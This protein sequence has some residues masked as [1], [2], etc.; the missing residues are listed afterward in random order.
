MKDNIMYK[1]RLEKYLVVFN[2]LKL[3]YT[4]INSRYSI[5]N[6]KIVTAWNKA[7]D[8][9]KSDEL[10]MMA[11]DIVKG[12]EASCK[13]DWHKENKWVWITPELLLRADKREFWVNNYISNHHVNK[14]TPF[15]K[16]RY[17]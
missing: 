15:K 7:V 1:E 10:D 16:N 5:N 8:G 3:K 2:E 17:V 9:L 14:S 11:M 12:L 13:S 4:G 6:K